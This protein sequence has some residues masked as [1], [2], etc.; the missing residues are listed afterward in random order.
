MGAALLAPMLFDNDERGYFQTSLITTPLLA[1]GSMAL[2]RALPA[3]Q[4]EFS[5]MRGVFKILP[6][7]RS[8]LRGNTQTARARARAAA[9]RR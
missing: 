4:G 1:A 9:G 5:R 6:E 8:L 2:D 7:T 3:I